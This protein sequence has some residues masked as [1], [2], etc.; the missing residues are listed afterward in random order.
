[1]NKRTDYIVTGKAFTREYLRTA[2]SYNN[3]NK[4]VNVKREIEKGL[5]ENKNSLTNED[6]L[7]EKEMNDTYYLVLERWN[8]YVFWVLQIKKKLLFVPL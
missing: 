2:L 5:I 3:M 8:K 6:K 4:F 1:M 7:K